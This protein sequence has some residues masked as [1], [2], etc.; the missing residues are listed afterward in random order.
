M[1]YLPLAY[2]D[3]LTSVSLNSSLLFLEFSVFIFVD[4]AG[5]SRVGIIGIANAET[6]AKGDSVIKIARKLRFKP[7]IILP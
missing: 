4:S 6:D 3:F 2:L 1:K 7:N 5:K